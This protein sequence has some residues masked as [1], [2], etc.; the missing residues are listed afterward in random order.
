MKAQ[1]RQPD[2]QILDAD[3]IFDADFVQFWK[4]EHEVFTRKG[5]PP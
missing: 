3:I 4:Q 2:R 5:S 1:P